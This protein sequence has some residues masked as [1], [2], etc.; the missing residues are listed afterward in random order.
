M[1]LKQHIQQYLQEA[2]LMHLATVSGGKPWVCSVWFAAD[3]DM[4][5]YW[6]SAVTRRH[7]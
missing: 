6:F 7:S 4:N 5:L 3:E 2:K 1:R